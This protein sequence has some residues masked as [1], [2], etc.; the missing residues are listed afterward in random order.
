MHTAAMSDLNPQV[1]IE[2]AERRVRRSSDPLVALHY[3]LSETR[4]REAL[5]VIVVADH[6]GMVLGGAGSWP[7]C[8]E[9]AAYAP[10]L[11]GPRHTPLDGRAQE[12]LDDAWVAP[13]FAGGD[14]ML[15]C[16]LGPSQSPE[17]LRFAMDGVAR[18]LAA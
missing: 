1:T 13:F 6:Q 3:H 16:G 11:S 8:E 14:E 10:L 12:V 17:R 5:A 9:L 15:L 4:R 2:P 7:I 18:I